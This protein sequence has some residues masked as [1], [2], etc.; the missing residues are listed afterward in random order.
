MQKITQAGRTRFAFGEWN[1][2]IETKKKKISDIGIRYVYH[3][4]NFFFFV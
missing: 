4:R 2:F 1:P 3:Y